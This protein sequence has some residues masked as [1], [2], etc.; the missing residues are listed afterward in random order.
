VDFG[1]MALWNRLRA[2]H[3]L[4]L[5]RDQRLR[6]A[7][8]LASH[9]Q[10]IDRGLHTWFFPAIRNIED[11]R[12]AAQNGAAVVVLGAAVQLLIVIFG[13]TANPIF[14]L[15]PAGVFILLAWGT[16]RM[17]R[18]AAL[19]GLILFCVLSA[20]AILSVGEVKAAEALPFALLFLS[21]WIS[22]VRG[23]FYFHR[24]SQNPV[25]DQRE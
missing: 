2:R 22:G 10:Q 12:G 25:S 3:R 18:T 24:H 23:T 20:P 7:G 16:W 14:S 21:M 11:A 9:D 1:L 17:S 8:A 15:F 19:A 4:N 5:E 13:M 6:D